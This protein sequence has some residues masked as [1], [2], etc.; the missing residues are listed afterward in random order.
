MAYI[1]R[2]IYFTIYEI[3]YIY[4]KIYEFFYMIHTCAFR[5]GSIGTKIGD[6]E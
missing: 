4:A 1:W 2:T 6:L 3:T 5:M